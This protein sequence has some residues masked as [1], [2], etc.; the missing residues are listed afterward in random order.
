[1]RG[2]Q[3]PKFN[4]DLNGVFICL[5]YASIQHTLKVYQTGEFIE[6]P[7]FTA[8]NLA[9]NSIHPPTDIMIP[10]ADIIRHL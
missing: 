6:P 3:D 5:V 4:S 8:F 10:K 2:A 7:L 1:M 9:S